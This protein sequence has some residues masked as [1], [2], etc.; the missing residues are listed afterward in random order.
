MK[1]KDFIKMLQ[2]ADP[3]GEGY[4]RMEGG[5]PYCAI[6]KE[7]YWDGPYSYIDE[8]GN[9]VYS[10]EGYKI[11]LC[12][13]DV[14]GFVERHFDLHEPN[15]WENIK[16]KF[17]FKLGGYCNPDSRNERADQIIK[18]AKEQF[19][20]LT[21]IYSKFLKEST[22]EAVEKYKKGWRYFQ[23]K[24]VEEDKMYYYYSW[25][26]FEP[27]FIK[28]HSSSVHDT[29]GV[30]HSGLFEKHDNYLREGYYEWKLIE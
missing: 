15:N 2:E 29:N 18:T 3:T 13:I 30:L 22:E 11:D 24:K 28:V 10:I 27:N 14:D 8:K 20:L 16:S 5:I 19:D 4:L 7:G 6:P 9:Y 17:I 25:K 23:N 26:I 12:C 21:E 1:T